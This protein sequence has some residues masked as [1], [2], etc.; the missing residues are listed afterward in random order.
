MQTMDYDTSQMKTYHYW[1]LAIFAVGILL[2]LLMLD[3]M[4]FHH[5]ESIHAMHSHYVYR[6]FG[7]VQI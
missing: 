6:G 4:A 1:I 3:T 7:T 5:D 2:R